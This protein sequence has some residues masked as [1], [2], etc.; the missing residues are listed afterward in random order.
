MTWIAMELESSIEVPQWTD[1][2][3]ADA[4]LVAMWGTYITAL[5]GHEY[6]HW[7]YLYRQARDIARKLYRVESPTCTLM[8]QMA[9]STVARINDRHWKLNE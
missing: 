4:R 3:A 1:R 7:E 2:K 6:T 8:K 9:S 5:H